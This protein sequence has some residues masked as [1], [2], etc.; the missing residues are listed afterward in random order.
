MLTH[1]RAD[2]L[3][4]G[5]L[6]YALQLF[7][8]MQASG[9]SLG[10]STCSALIYACMHT[11]NPKAAVRIYETLRFQGIMPRSAQ[12]SCAAIAIWSQPLPGGD[13]GMRALCS[14]PCVV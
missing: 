11:N 9:I 8:D 13:M 14:R 12:V 6:E 4:V 7:N 2:P 1:P 10:R 5:K 3:Q